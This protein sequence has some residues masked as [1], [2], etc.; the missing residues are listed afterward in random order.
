MTRRMVSIV[1]ATTRV[2]Y[3]MMVVYLF[4]LTTCIVAIGAMVVADVEALYRKRTGR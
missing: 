1:F 4:D 2:S 3:S